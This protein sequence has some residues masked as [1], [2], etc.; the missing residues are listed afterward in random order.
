MAEMEETS[1]SAMLSSIPAS[2]PPTLSS[3]ACEADRSTVP[4]EQGDNGSATAIHSPSNPPSTYSPL[5][6]LQTYPESENNELQDNHSSKIA[7]DKT[8]IALLLV[9]GDRH[10]FEFSL[11]DTVSGA[12][13]YIFQHWPSGWSDK[14]PDSPDNLELVYLGKFLENPSTLGSNR[15]PGGQATIVHLVIRQHHKQPTDDAVDSDNIP[16]CKC[17]TIL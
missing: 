11:D 10:T 13:T 1:S 8:R 12:K 16:R 14:A 6:S 15:L 9:S 17:C 4:T 5:P 3:Y 2:I 7:P